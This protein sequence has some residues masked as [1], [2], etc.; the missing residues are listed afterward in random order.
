MQLVCNSTYHHAS[1]SIKLYAAVPSIY[2]CM[3]EI[4]QAIRDLLRIELTPWNRSIALPPRDEKGS[5]VM[6]FHDGLY[7][8]DAHGRSLRLIPPPK[9][10]TELTQILEKFTALYVEEG[11]A[12]KPYR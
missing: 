4:A 5:Y 6:T 2:V 3:Q 10:V 1:L 11:W 7:Y 9:F 8:T 12:L